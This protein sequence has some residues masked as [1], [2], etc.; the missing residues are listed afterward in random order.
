MLQ[1]SIGVSVVCRDF[2]GDVAIITSCFLIYGSQNLKC[3]ITKVSENQLIID[4]HSR[5]E[6]ARIGQK[7]VHGVPGLNL[8]R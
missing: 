6:G 7:N 3:P 5:H 8:E 1:S 2:P 4:K